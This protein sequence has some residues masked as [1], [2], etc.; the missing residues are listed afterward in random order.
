VRPHGGL[1]GHRPVARAAGAGREAGGAAQ[2]AHRPVVA[3]AL[4]VVHQRDGLLAQVGERDVV[5]PG[6]G[7]VGGD[8]DDGRLLEQP[9]AYDAPDGIGAEADRHVEVAA[10]D[11]VGQDARGLGAR[12]HAHV[13]VA[14]GEGGEQLL[15][16]VVRAGG[17]A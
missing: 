15:R 1:P 3:G 9:L 11:L 10:G 8:R 14:L 13:R 5:A 2:R 17:Q 4:A 7:M 6:Q 16:G 12:P